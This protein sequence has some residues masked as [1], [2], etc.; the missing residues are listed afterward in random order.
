MGDNSLNTKRKELI[1]EYFYIVIGCFLFSV[2]AVALVE[3]YGF[4]PGGVYGLSIVFHH[5]FGWE[6]EITALCMDI[7]LLIIGTIILGPKFGIKTLVC[8]LLVPFFM[9]ILHKTYGYHSIIEPEISKDIMDQG[10]TGV[11]ALHLY[12]NQLLAAIFGGVVYGIGLGLIFK[13]RAT[14]GGSDIIAMIANKYFHLSLGTCIIIIDGI[15]TLSTVIAFGDWRLPMYSWI[16]IFI[17]SKIIDMVVAGKAVKT[18]MIISSE[19]EAVKKVIL[20]DLGRG[21]TLLPAVGMYKG[22][23]RDMIYTTLTR[24]EMFTLRYKIADIDPKAFIN[25]VDSSETL[26]LGFKN[27]TE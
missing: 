23:K 14:S 5:L 1:L 6:T 18:V 3:P 10:I 19:T 2:G 8:V 7:P 16:I 15:I 4:A 12:K 9:W 21:A 20:E 22:D 27:I 11:Q 17:E 25:V 26:G 24:R 13:S